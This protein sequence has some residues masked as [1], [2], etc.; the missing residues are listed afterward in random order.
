[1]TTEA[2]LRFPASLSKRLET[3][4]ASIIYTTPYQL[5]Q[6]VDRGG[7]HDRDVS[8]VRQV[9]FGGEAFAPHALVALGQ[10]FPN[11]DLLNVYGPAEVNGVTVHSFGRAPAELQSVPIGRPCPGVDILLVDESDGLVTDGESGEI[12][13][14]SPT[15]MSGY[16]KSPDLN[17]ACFVEIGGVTFYRTGDRAHLDAQGWLQFEGR[18]DN[19]IK[20]R[21]V[22]IDLEAIERVLEDAPGVAHAVAGRVDDPTG[23]QQ[24]M[25]WIVPA[26]DTIDTAAVI[27]WCRDRLPA[28]AV[29]TVLQS[30]TSVP[31]TA[32]GKIDRASL[33]ASVASIESD[34]P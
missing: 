23:I 25:A 27:A 18:R 34:A 20:V 15:M 9:A 17:E 1:M 30:I 3:A 16:W 19:L 8:A 11:A 32:T 26:V 28:N 31:T 21:G 5:Q 13:V 33:R 4:Q 22:R 7:L 29:P 6:L 24:I 12:L 14:H 10:H 2:E